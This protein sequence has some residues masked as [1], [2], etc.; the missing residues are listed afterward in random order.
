MSASMHPIFLIR[1]YLGLFRDSLGLFRRHSILFKRSAHSA[2]PR[3]FSK[4]CCLKV[5]SVKLLA[6]WRS[7][8]FF[9]RGLVPSGVVLGVFWEH[10][11]TQGQRLGS[12]GAHLGVLWVPFLGS[13]GLLWGPLGPPGFF[14]YLHGNEGR[15][16]ALGSREPNPTGSPGIPQVSQS[17]PTVP[18]YTPR[19]HR[20]HLARSDK[21]LGVP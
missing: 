3:S 18:R 9:F 10:L 4:R 16:D 6:R 12:L 11:G 14:E 20:H 5:A 21:S 8:R 2:G 7:H 17:I 13:W 1:A 19:R 15:P